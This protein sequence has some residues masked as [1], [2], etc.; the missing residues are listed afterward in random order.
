[1]GDMYGQGFQRTPDGQIIY[2]AN[3]LPAELD[4]VVRR[5]GNAFADWK[6]GLLNEFTVKGFRVSILFD[7]Q[8]GGSVYSQTNHKLNTLGK[9]KVTLPGRDGG[10]I[11]EGVVRQA[12][13]TFLPN[14]RTVPAM[15]YY[16][17]YYK[18]RNAETNIFDAS[19][20]KLREA[21]I[22]WSLPAG[23]VGKVA[24]QEATIALYG[25]DLFLFTRFPA[26]DPEVAMLNS[27]TIVPGVEMT[28]FPSTRTMG[29]NLTVKF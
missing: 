13:G 10:L 12:D 15:N 28:Q 14:T 24:M 16:D 5:W 11:G 21:R 29:L 17:E 27:G 3:G 22:A 26:F 25:R 1:M 6:A 9:T 7:G 2:A 18:I 8:K 20:I 4:P 19:F 23:L